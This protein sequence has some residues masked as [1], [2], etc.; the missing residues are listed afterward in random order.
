MESKDCCLIPES[1]FYLEG[2]GG[3]YEYV[4]Q[5]LKENRHV[6][7][8][9]AEGAG[10]EYVAQSIIRVS[11]SISPLESSADNLNLGV[12]LPCESMGC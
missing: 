7:I 10:Q 11:S 9:L 1:P 3:L 8:V 2:P 12:V 5:Q 4:E 6:L